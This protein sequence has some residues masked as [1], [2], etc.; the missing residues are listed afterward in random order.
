MSSGSHARGQELD[1]MATAW[2]H[3]SGMAAAWQRHGGMAA[4]WQRHGNG[5]A[6][7]RHGNGQRHGGMATAWLEAWLR[8]GYGTTA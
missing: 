3:G 5:M 4:A 2:R 1:G 7:R 6:A 8:H